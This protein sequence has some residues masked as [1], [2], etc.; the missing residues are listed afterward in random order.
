MTT[1]IRIEVTRSWS[2]SPRTAGSNARDWSGAGGGRSDAGGGRERGGGV[3]GGGGGTGV[4]GGPRGGPRGAAPAGADVTSSGPWGRGGRFC[5]SPP[6]HF[7]AAS[8]RC[9]ADAPG[10]GP[11]PS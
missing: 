2:D 6:R 3:G 4:G 11:G 7:R 8:R 10:G 9:S 1:A 5:W